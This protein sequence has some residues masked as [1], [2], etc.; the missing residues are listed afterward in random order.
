MD[1]D[2]AGVSA[3]LR[4]T[5]FPELLGLRTMIDGTPRSPVQ[6]Y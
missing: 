1:P 4:L 3:D 2:V 5:F 6:G